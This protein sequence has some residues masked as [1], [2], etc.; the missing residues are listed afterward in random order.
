VRTAPADVVHA[1]GLQTIPAVVAAP[2]DRLVVTPRAGDI[3]PS[4]VTM[5]VRLLQPR[6][7]GQ[8]LVDAARVIAGSAGEIDVLAADVGVH[9]DRIA[10]VPESIPTDAMRDVLPFRSDHPVAVVAGRVDRFSRV[11]RVVTALSVLPAFELVIVGRDAARRGLRRFADDL[12]LADRVRFVD[13]N[14]ALER[15]RW[16]R[17]ADV[18]VSVAERGTTIVPLLEALALGTPVVA[19]GTPAHCELPEYARPDMLR[20]VSPRSS[21]LAIADAIEALAGSERRPTPAADLPT[22]ETALALV[23]EVY[24]EVAAGA[25]SAR[26]LARPGGEHP[27]ARR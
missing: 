22:A 26:V 1:H 11:D 4:R 16:L 19:S 5:L 18:A 3:A 12:D 20:L 6:R 2:P 14:A 7:P 23:L 15:R 9:E 17:T 21:P 8:T 27:A 24:K 13:T 25:C 10:L